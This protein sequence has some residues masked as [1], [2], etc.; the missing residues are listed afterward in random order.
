LP[1]KHKLIRIATVPMALAYPLQGQSSYM[2]QHG[3]DVTMISS[4]GREM[5]LLL[6]QENCPHIIV[7]MT[8]SITPFR[9]IK[10][11][12]QLIRI[13]KKLK[14][15]IVHTE[16]PK[17]GLVGMIA[18]K[19]CGVRVRIHTVAGLPLM[20]EKGVKLRILEWVEKI[21]YAAAT[22][23]WPNSNSLKNF[24]LQHR[25]TSAKKLLVVGKGSSN[26]I[27]IDR[28]SPEK[29]GTTI[30]EEIK[31]NIQYNKDNV[32]LLFIGRLVLDKGI[33]E[34]IHVF[35]KLYEKNPKLKLILAGHFERSLDPLPQDVEIQIAENK[36]IIHIN[37]TDKVPY[38]LALSNI[39]VF[40]S[41]REGFPNVLLEAGAMKL[42]IVCS[43][44][45]GNVDIVE[46]NITGRIF[47]SQNENDLERVLT[48]ALDN[49]EHMKEMASSLQQNIL[50]NYCREVFWQTMLEE[51][52]KL[53]ICK[54]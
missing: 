53:L 26:G 29:L 31:Q 16:T 21:T 12:F 3:M 48:D 10:C 47:E 38:Y 7:P 33:V 15:D 44:I 20:V 9:D 14:P 43:R 1:E 19:L 45:A 22:N 54:K 2:H 4:D 50:N 36:N 49:M 32:Y 37:W 30:L 13:F 34:L 40:P 35:K 51:Y 25:F 46:D 28:F 42:P 18:A 27:D 8:R 23:V 39:F 5:K 6:Q 11:I 17:A 41:Y 24:I 52:K